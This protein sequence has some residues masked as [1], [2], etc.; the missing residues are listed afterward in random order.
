MK[1]EW[2]LSYW[3][4]EYFENPAKDYVN[5]TKFRIDDK[6]I[7]WYK[8]GFNSELNTEM[9]YQYSCGEYTDK[10]D[11]IGS[12]IEK[13]PILSFTFREVDLVKELDK[14]IPK[15]GFSIINNQIHIDKTSN[16]ANNSGFLLETNCIDADLRKIYLVDWRYLIIANNNQYVLYYH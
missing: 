15:L 4:N 6:K 16:I 13:N 12:T 10:K 5:F 14:D 11:S 7:Y 2:S 9:V 3:R 8:A 1:G